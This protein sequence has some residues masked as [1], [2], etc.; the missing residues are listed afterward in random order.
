MPTAPATTWRVTLESQRCL[1]SPKSLL[2]N[3]Y[4]FSVAIFLD[5]E[6]ELPTLGFSSTPPHKVINVVQFEPNKGAMGKAYKKDA[7]IAMDF[8]SMC[9]ECYITDQEKLL[10]ET[11]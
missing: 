10:N 1:W 3:P 6:R 5:N 4:P 9:D 2:K 11:G 7:K 8:L